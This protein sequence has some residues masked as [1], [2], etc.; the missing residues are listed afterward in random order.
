MNYLKG[1]VNKMKL[2]EI[3]DI[4]V[5]QVRRVFVDDLPSDYSGWMLYVIDE[6]ESN[7]TFWCDFYDA[8][9]FCER[10]SLSKFEIAKDEIIGKIGITHEIKDGK[11]V[12]IPRRGFETYD[13]VKDEDDDVFVLTSYSSDGIS[14]GMN[15]MTVK[16]PIKRKLQKIGI[17]GVTHEFVNESEGK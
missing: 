7:E 4:K 16:F 1:K 9:G 8:K 10:L 3:S 15:G 13:V 6:Q 14:V 2:V 12:E 17:Y 5:G 11:L